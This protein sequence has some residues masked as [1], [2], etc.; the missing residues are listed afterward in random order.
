[1]LHEYAVVVNR[2][3]QY[4]LVL[5]NVSS[6]GGPNSKFKMNMSITTFSFFISNL[7]TILSLGFS[8]TE[9]LVFMMIPKTVLL[10]IRQAVANVERAIIK[11][12]ERQYN[13]I[14]TPLKNSVPKKLGMQVQKLARR[15]STALYYVPPQVGIH[16]IIEVQKIIM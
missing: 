11:A 16:L 13:D 8:C 3:P 2:W 6:S 15:Q 4:T 12:L 9:V 10:A 7:T 1:M 5:E 14:L